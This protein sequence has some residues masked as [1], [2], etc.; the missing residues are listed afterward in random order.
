MRGVGCEPFAT[1]LKV[2]FLLCPTT[3]KSFGM[4]MARESG[5][6]ATFSSREET[7]RDLGAFRLRP[8]VFEINP[9]AGGIGD[10]DEGNT[11]RVR[12]IEFES[13]GEF[14]AK[15]RLA[16]C[17]VNKPYLV[18]PLLEIAPQ[19]ITQDSA[20]DNETLLIALEMKTRTPATFIGA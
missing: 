11:G 18:R 7:P 3:E 1:G 19:E 12:E 6:I 2:S 16:E 15:I 9:D 5:Q 17:I 13:A 4:E 20:R 8:D 10:G 14:R